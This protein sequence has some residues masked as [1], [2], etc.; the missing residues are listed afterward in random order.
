MENRRGERNYATPLP[1]H[2]SS[3]GKKKVRYY[4]GKN[5][6][7]TK[8]SK[9]TVYPTPTIGETEVAFMGKA[10]EKNLWV[11][12]KFRVRESARTTRSARKLV[13]YT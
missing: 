5:I 2:G 3:E 13:L 7:I 4:T 1:R 12:A 10:R 6:F 11:A 8:V 9:S